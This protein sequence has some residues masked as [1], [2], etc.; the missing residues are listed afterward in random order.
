[1]SEL[2]LSPRVDYHR[3][4]TI[5]A[6]GQMLGDQLHGYWEWY[7]TDGTLKRSGH[8]DHGNQVG[9]WTT[10]DADSLPYKITQMKPK[11]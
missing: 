2:T 1:V 4:G 6:K 10:Y 7:R 9:E 11:S 5:C 3:G 8:F